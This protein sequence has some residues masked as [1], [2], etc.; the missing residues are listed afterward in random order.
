[1]TSVLPWVQNLP[2]G[3]DVIDTGF[4]RPQFDASYLIAQAGRAAFIDTGTNDS[5][6]RLLAALA[7]RG[8]SV[9]AVDW[10]IA[11]HVHLDHAGGVGELMRHLPC[12]KL[13]VHPRGAASDQPQQVGSRGSSRLRCRSGSAHLRH[14]GRRAF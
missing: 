12:A 8:L 5:V 7:A 3:I 2:H 9:E 13:V 1:M 14:G 4:Q 6:P 10:V 11:T